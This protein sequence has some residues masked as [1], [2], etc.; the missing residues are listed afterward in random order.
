MPKACLKYISLF[1]SGCIAILVYFLIQNILQYTTQR[2]ELLGHFPADVKVTVKNLAKNGH[3]E[4]LDVFRIRG[5][6]EL[7]RVGT[8]Y[9]NKHV[10]RLQFEFD[11]PSGE[12]L[13]LGRI[14]LFFPY[15]GEHYYTEENI[16]KYFDS[17]HS[18]PESDLFIKLIFYRRFS[19]TPSCG[20]AKN[21][22][23]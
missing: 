23:I 18:T 3:I 4:E 15:L 2:I 21:T 14:K 1:V 22:S 20:L 16:S 6:K 17:V 12:A 13:A 19:I 8:T 5:S 9:I 11:N 7:Q 10:H